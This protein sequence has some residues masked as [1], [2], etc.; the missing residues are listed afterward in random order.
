MISRKL[1]EIEEGK[2]GYPYIRDYSSFV[3]GVTGPLGA[4]KS[5][6]ISQLVKRLRKHKVAVLLNDPKGKGAFLG[7]RLRM[8]NLPDDVFVR[9][10]ASDG[11]ISVSCFRMI[12]LMEK[13]GY[14]RIIVETCGSGQSDTELDAYVDAVVLVLAPGLGDEIQAMKS[15]VNE[16]ADIIVVNKSDRRGAERALREIEMITEPKGI[17]VML[18][19][20]TKG[21]G[22][23]RL[24]EELDR[25][26]HKSFTIPARRE[27]RFEKQLSIMMHDE[28]SRAIDEKIQHAMPALV[29]RARSGSSI[30]E[31]AEGYL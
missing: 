22:F 26:M 20:S 28:L 24:Q 31:L 19:D 17:P 10:I 16:I 9:S 2:P 13:E 4:G 5:T 23:T 29:A 8:R 27:K 1:T 30:R 14:D 25:C 3:I 6:L 15:G 11:S 21:T 18:T 12:A 7:D